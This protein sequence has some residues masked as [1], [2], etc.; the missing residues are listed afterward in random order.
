MEEVGHSEDGQE[1]DLGP[2]CRHPHPQGER[3]EGVGRHRGL[4]RKEGGA[5]DDAHT[6]AVRDG[7]RGIVR[8]NGARRGG[9]PQLRDCATHQ[10]GNGAL[11]G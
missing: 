7:A 11:V 9:A 6:P 1:E 10:V 8:W 5:I 2:H 3:L 4:P